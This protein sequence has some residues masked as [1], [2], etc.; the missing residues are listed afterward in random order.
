M[1]KVVI[2]R[3]PHTMPMFASLRGYKELLFVEMGTKY[4]DGTAWGAL[5]RTTCGFK[6]DSRVAGDPMEVADKLTKMNEEWV[7]PC[8]AS[9]LKI[10]TAQSADLWL[11]VLAGHAT[12]YDQSPQPDE[13]L[14]IL[15]ESRF[16][17]GEDVIPAVIEGGIHGGSL[18]LNIVQNGRNQGSAWVSVHVRGD[19]GSSKFDF[20]QTD[21]T[22]ANHL[23]NPLADVHPLMLGQLRDPSKIVPLRK[24]GT[25]D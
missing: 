23:A 5:E 9:P 8:E 6:K 15:G 2:K 19:I 1:Q 14:D 25:A 20:P 16:N 21:V 10:S 13:P 22:Q 7:W 12:G 24:W 17:V 18:K 4:D 11:R 3:V